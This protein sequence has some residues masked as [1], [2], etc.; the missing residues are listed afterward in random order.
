M[1]ASVA[2]Y[3]IAMPEP[4]ASARVRGRLRDELTERGMSQRDLAEK[5]THETGE[6]WTQSRVGKV[7]NGDVELKIDDVEVISKALGIFL[8]EAV[9]DRGLE[10]YAEL[11]PTEMRMF[12]I[13]KQRP[14]LFQMAIQALHGLQPIPLP[15]PK[16]STP[17]AKRRKP[18]RPLNSELAK[19]QAG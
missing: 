16:T 15:N 13:Y 7:L 18:G 17:V 5:L 2:P 9:R 3:S 6:S 11:T 4:T 19:K 10:F 14:G 8:S 1:R 12:T